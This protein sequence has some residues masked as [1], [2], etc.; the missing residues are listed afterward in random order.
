MKTRIHSILARSLT[1]LLLTSISHATLAE[2]T[3]DGPQ[4]HWKYAAWGK[5]VA[6]TAVF[7]ELGVFLDKRTNG[8][9]KFTVHFGT[10]SKPKAILDGLS[11]GAF[12]GGTVVA[13]FYPGK[14]DAA[15]ALDLPFM[16]YT[17][18]AQLAKAT[19][20]YMALPEIKKE[21]NKWGAMYYMTSA[22][23]PF[24]VIG[25]GVPP[26]KLSDW[27]GVKIR[28][29]G[30]QGKAMKAIGAVPVGKRGP[31]VYSALDTNLVSA[32]A[33]GLF[34]LEGYKIYELGKWYTTDF[35]LGSIGA[36]MAFNLEAYNSLPPQYKALLQEYKDHV[37]YKVQSKAHAICAVECPKVFKKAGLTEVKYTQ[38]DRDEFAAKAAKPVW[39]DWIKKMNKKGYDG[40][41]LFDTLF[42]SLKKN[43]NAQP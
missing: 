30:Q 25:K 34:A 40:Q 26:R 7:R 14:M 37:G 15:T 22:L 5:P 38:A 42:N 11:V 8:K 4:I 10:L 16:P 6:W 28:A 21:F 27:K 32:A 1:V 31:Q 41:K 29:I 19:D 33:M 12:Q 20:E 35:G 9:F 18:T 43:A 39:S 3:V 24:E 23:P 36:H 17:S 13:G 2:K